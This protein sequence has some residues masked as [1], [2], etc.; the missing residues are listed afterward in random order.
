M[1]TYPKRIK[2]HDRIMGIQ[3]KP[4]TNNMKTFAIKDL[5]QNYYVRKE[6]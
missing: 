5:I 4:W 1:K 3:V 6:R 2:L